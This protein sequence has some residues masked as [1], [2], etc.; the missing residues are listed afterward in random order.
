M[1]NKAWILALS[2]LST[3][4]CSRV[5]L[6][7]GDVQARVESRE[8]KR[9]LRLLAS[10]DEAVWQAAYW[11]LVDRGPAVSGM[12]IQALDAREPLAGRAMLVL[13]ELADPATL[14][15]LKGLEQD[16]RLAAAA[17]RAL[18]ISEEALWRRVEETQ[19][20]ASCEAYLTWFPGGQHR[21]ATQARLHELDASAAFSALGPKPELE[22][23]AQFLQNFGDTT[24][25]ERLK[26]SLALESVDS[27]ETAFTNGDFPAAL[28][29]IDK[30]RNWDPHLDF[31]DLEGRIR[32][33]LGRSLVQEGASHRAIIELA[34]ARALGAPVEMELGRLL[35]ERAR[36]RQETR[37]FQG[38]LED[39]DV[40]L[41][42]YPN[43]EAVIKRV[44][45]AIE[46]QLLR[47]I[48]KG[49]LDADSVA[50]ALLR[51]GPKGQE[52]LTQRLDGGKTRALVQRL[53]ADAALGTD[54]AEM[55][56]YRLGAVQDVVKISQANAEVFFED[57]LRLRRLLDGERLWDPSQGPTRDAARKVVGDTIRALRWQTEL[58]QRLPATESNQAQTSAGGDRLR[59]NRELEALLS[60]HKGPDDPTLDLTV[61]VQLLDQ[62][63]RSHS[64]L[65]ARVRQQPLLFAAGLVGLEAIPTDLT[66]WGAFMLKSPD[67]QAL[68]LRN[69]TPAR[70][71][72]RRVDGHLRLRL[73]V[74][75]SDSLN[76]ELA[77]S[78]A[79][80]L[81][82]GSARSL[83]HHHSDLEGVSVEVGGGKPIGAGD[84]TASGDSFALKARVTM[85]RASIRRFNWKIIQNAAPFGIAH[86]A[87]VFDQEIH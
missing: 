78:E 51:A 2:L 41:S 76:T 23:L 59:L 27:A 18:E 58:A 87:F 84:P 71:E 31:A 42:V 14:A 81:L 28:H 53:I 25:G 22:A 3:Q 21:W 54:T 85:S 37:D 70:L 73:I 10:K 74:T 67:P 20:R 55:R 80:T 60:V 77:V 44:R 29:E 13:G 75:D 30:A 49:A 35:V 65:Q 40:A 57:G 34:K 24:V 16:P 26:K 6:P 47:E 63:L 50:S 43:L 79:L 8:V 32:G 68:V 56:A 61:R 83:V 9:Q 11:H 48:A 45:R 15:H 82:F 17:S 64:A 39:L 69:G 72:A 36:K 7:L 52:A 5:W 1:R 46:K 62:L 12:L 38:G 19:D 33:G 86:L 66:A 4:G